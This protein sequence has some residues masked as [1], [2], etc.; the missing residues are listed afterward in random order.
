M[1][2]NGFCHSLLQ[3]PL[4]LAHRRI[5]VLMNEIWLEMLRCAESTCITVCVIMNLF[6]RP[7]NNS[8]LQLQLFFVVV[9]VSISRDGCMWKQL[10]I[11][12]S[13]SSYRPPSVGNFRETNHI[14]LILIHEWFQWRR[15]RPSTTIDVDFRWTKNH[16][17][18]SM[19]SHLFHQKHDKFLVHQNHWIHNNLQW[20]LS[21]C[22]SLPLALWM[23]MTWARANSDVVTTV[24]RP[25]PYSASPTQHSSFSWQ[26]SQG[27]PP[28]FSSLLNICMREREKECTERERERHTDILYRWE[29]L[30]ANNI[31]VLKP[32]MEAETKMN[33]KCFSIKN[34][35][36]KW[37]SFV[38]PTNKFKLSWCVFVLCFAKALHCARTKSYTRTLLRP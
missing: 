21:S 16:P 18:D 35:T 1:K 31:G 14:K 30:R 4:A 13:S 24:I 19:C 28:S 7:K 37:S 8:L 20:K 32:E 34:E 11:V 36:R 5:A 29:T 2:D 3:L 27:F 6:I 25:S 22:V 26:I 23:S 17:A 38:D 12:L 33:E 15:R 9:C 10:S